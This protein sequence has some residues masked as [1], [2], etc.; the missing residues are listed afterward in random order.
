MKSAHIQEGILGEKAAVKH[1]EKIG[2]EIIEQNYK[3]RYGEIDIIAV[4][5]LKS[6]PAGRQE[7]TLVFVEV[8]TRSSSEFGTPLEAI[9]PWKI[10]SVIKTAQFYTLSHKNLPQLLRIDAIAVILGPLN[11]IESL[12]HVKNITGY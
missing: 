8:K 1:L 10:R 6:L 5:P 2:Y 9:T 4:D 12:D 11:E 7:R 3:I